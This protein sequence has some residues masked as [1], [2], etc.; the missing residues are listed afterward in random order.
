LLPRSQNA[1]V[2]GF[3]Q[4]RGPADPVGSAH[5]FGSKGYARCR[6]RSRE[7]GVLVIS[8][9][10]VIPVLRI[11]NIEKADEFYLGF[12]GFTV[13]WDHRFDPAG[14][15][16]RQISRGNL[17]LH[18]SEH[19]GDGTPGVHVRVMMDGVEAFQRE[20][21]SKGYPYMRPGLETMPWGMI[22]T[23]VIDPFGNFIR[24]CQRV[25]RSTTP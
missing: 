23:G 25:E 11:F 22:E 14:P 2:P 19:H 3:E 13:D 12:L 6:A 18:L 5:I 7:G 24:F 21:S 9:N 8:F 1:P 4:G 10:S 16:Y 15:L 20:I 17:I